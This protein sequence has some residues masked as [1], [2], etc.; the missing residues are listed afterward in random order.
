MYH[1]EEKSDLNIAPTHPVNQSGVYSRAWGRVKNAGHRAWPASASAR[2][3][4][5]RSLAVLL[6]SLT[7]GIPPG[8]TSPAAPGRSGIY[9][10]AIRYT[11]EPLRLSD[12]GGPAG[13]MDR[14]FPRIRELG[15][16]AVFVSHVASE[17]RDTVLRAARSHN[18]G[19]ILPHRPILRYVCSGAGDEKSSSVSEWGPVGLSSSALEP[20]VV[21]LHLGRVGDAPAAA[22]AARVADALARSA[23]DLRVCATIAPGCARPGEL[24]TAVIPIVTVPASDHVSGCAS[25][26]TDGARRPAGAPRPGIMMIPVTGLCDDV[27]AT[28]RHWLGMYHAGLCAGGTCGVVMDAYAEVPGRQQGLVDRRGRLTVER[29]AAIKRIVNRAQHWGPLICGAVPEV[30]HGAEC[31]DEDLRTVLLTR[32]RR[33]FILVANTSVTRFVR[34]RVTLP[35]QIGRAP[36]QRAVR[37]PGDPGVIGGSVAPLRHGE[38]RLTVDLAP[39]DANLYELF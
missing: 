38:I 29:S 37:V 4:G 2:S 13:A 1:H 16:N 20:P 14:D 25:D 17:D 28:V 11:V 12:A 39:G 26:P 33:R 10:I 21:M 30:L 31:F 9:P 7:G 8:C 36:A 15:F 6:L 32:R 5:G 34:T 23:P 22:R 3:V 24:G 18:L 27:D 35:E 19:V